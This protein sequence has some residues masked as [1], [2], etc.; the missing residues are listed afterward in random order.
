LAAFAAFIDPVAGQTLD[1]V[2][3]LA[4]QG[5]V[6]EARAS[7]SRWWE[8][9]S[10]GATR[11]DTQRA[12]WLRALLTSDARQA[13]LDYRRLTVEY[14]GGEYA[15]EALFRLTQEAAS[16]EDWSGAAEL[17]RILQ[18]DYPASPRGAQARAWLEERRAPVASSSDPPRAPTAA[19]APTTAVAPTTTVAPTTAVAP[20]TT[21][22]P[23]TA[24][25]PPPAQTAGP[26][27]AAPAG[28][29]PRGPMA[30][31][32]GAFGALAGARALEARAKAAGLDVRLVHVQGSGLFHVRS[33]GFSDAAEAA[34]HRATA[35]SLGF[36]TML[37]GDVVLETPVP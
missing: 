3:D 26:P 23:A 22:A 28:S 14:P 33:G 18:R 32:L 4:R 21:V 5:Q 15:S 11:L 35:L 13:S 24:A 10:A 36:E 30:I 20:T 29:A 37:V 12:L 7:L 25:P 2:D 16:R 19:P 31:Q 27:S 17:A 1:R 34:A 8:T 9:E 6:R